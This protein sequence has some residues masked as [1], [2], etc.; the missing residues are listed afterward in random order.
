MP[1]AGL[2]GFYAEVRASPMAPLAEKLAHALD[3]LDAE[4][5]TSAD[6]AGLFEALYFVFRH[7]QHSVSE[8]FGM[9]DK[10]IHLEGKIEGTPRELTGW[11]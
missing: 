2:E 10:L 11:R 6:A 9:L 4:A 7:P 8:K 1:I 5:E 3:V